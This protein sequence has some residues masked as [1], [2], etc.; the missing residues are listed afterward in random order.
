[1]ADEAAHLAHVVHPGANVRLRE[2]DTGET[3]G[4]A[5]A[6]AGE[7][8]QKIDKELAELQELLYGAAKQSVL[9]VLQGMDT[10]GKDGTIRR[11]LTLLNPQACRVE[12]F[13]APSDEESAHDFLWRVH[14]RCPPYGFITIFNRSHYED[15]LAARVHK[16]VPKEVWS[17][18]FEQINAFERLL[19]ENGTILLKFFLHIGR[20]EQE[21]RL[22]DREREPDK[23]WKLSVSDWEDRQDWD[24]YQRAYEEA[25]ERCSTHEAPWYIVPADHRWFRDLAVAG[26][27]AARLRHHRRDWEAELEARGRKQLEDLQKYRESHPPG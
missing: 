3:S 12:S 10:S 25:L 22:L 5:H 9:I 24:H 18:R 16:I 19:T 14:Q 13:K 15:V 11:A 1:M 26:T 7:R 23:A 17:A 2:L 8:L 6:E 20:R 27:I 4:I 21:K